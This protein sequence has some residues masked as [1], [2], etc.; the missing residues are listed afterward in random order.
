MDREQAVHLHTLLGTFNGRMGGGE[1]I[2][3]NLFLLK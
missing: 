1:L 2:K 3:A